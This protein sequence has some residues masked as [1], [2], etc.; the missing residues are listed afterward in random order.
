[1]ILRLAR[2]L[3]LT[4]AA[5]LAA[6]LLAA[7]VLFGWLQHSAENLELGLETAVSFLLGRPLEIEQVSEYHLGENTRLVARN[8]SLANTDWAETAM[9][10]EVGYL[11][12]D[13]NIPSLWRAGPVLL[14]QLTLRQAELNLQQRGTSPGNW[15]FWQNREAEPTARDDALPLMIKQGQLVDGRLTF[16]D[17]DQ[18]IRAH[19]ETLSLADDGRDMLALSAVGEINDFPLQ[20]SGQAGPAQALVTGKQLKTD[21]SLQWGHLTL[22]IQGSA[23]DLKSLQGID[24]HVKLN[25]LTSRPLLELLGVTTDRD[26]KVSL[27]GHVATEDSGL[28]LS[29]Q[30]RLQAYQLSLNALIEQPMQLDG[31]DLTFGVEGPSLQETGAAFDIPSLPDVPYTVAGTLRRKGELLELEDTRIT[32]AESAML[33]SGRLPE[34]P[35]IDD[36]QMHVEGTRI[37]LALLAPLLGLEGM[38]DQPYDLSGN[39][40]A[41]DEGTELLDFQLTS[42]TS[43]MGLNGTVGQAPSYF[44]TRLHVELSGN[45]V[46][47][48]AP[49][50]GLQQLPNEAFRLS[51]DVELDQQGWRLRDGKLASDSLNMT[52][53]GVMDKLLN[54]TALDAQITL[55]SPDLAAALTSL[56]LIHI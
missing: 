23:L 6:A 1:M 49:W 18:A 8:V 43:R 42:G 46:A 26:G 55:A 44:G 52:L 4:A 25:S 30:G 41:D 11:E 3:T 5:I 12:A 16:T 17:D 10:A 27:Q 47:D 31:V 38:P 2:T 15:N 19:L 13:I 48:A 33:L 34:F 22:E 54:T 51:G 28:T 50:I 14:N 29:A 7:A 40:S 37:N 53:D 24:A 39:L 32:A 45:N 56:S 20:V 9:F 36:W 35:G 21:L